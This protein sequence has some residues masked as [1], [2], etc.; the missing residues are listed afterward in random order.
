MLMN[1][2]IK[3]NTQT[4][5]SSSYTFGL[6]QRQ[7]SKTDSFE[8]G[9]PT[10]EV[11]HQSVNEQI[12]QATGPILRQVE[13]FCALLASRIEMEPT[14]HGEATGLRLDNTSASSA[15]NRFNTIRFQN[16][17]QFCCLCSHISMITQSG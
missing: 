7:E 14:R 6:R 17:F 15:E 8:N 11:T 3:N 13:K 9:F 16:L 12:K 4:L 10:S 2:G 5:D 1:S